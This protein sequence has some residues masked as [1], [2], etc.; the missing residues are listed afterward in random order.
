MLC[1]QINIVHNHRIELTIN[2]YRC[3]IFNPDLIIIQ[4]LIIIFMM[5][6]QFIYSAAHLIVINFIYLI[7]ACKTRSI[8]WSI[9]S[10]TVHVQ[11]SNVTRQ[12][13]K[14]TLAPFTLGLWKPAYGFV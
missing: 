11:T 7:N 3:D 9:L 4:S 6:L 10:A 12:E 1:K 13:L 14:I 8:F 2:Y 5:I